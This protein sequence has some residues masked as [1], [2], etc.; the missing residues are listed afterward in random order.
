ML[1]IQPALFN[2]LLPMLNR[3]VMLSIHFL[4]Y[5]YYD[6]FPRKFWVGLCSSIK[7]NTLPILGIASSLQL[8]IVSSSLAKQA[9]SLFHLKRKQLRNGTRFSHQL[10]PAY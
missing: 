6:G 10:E 3:K 2:P 7:L 9:F 1:A 8:A 5:I 4:K